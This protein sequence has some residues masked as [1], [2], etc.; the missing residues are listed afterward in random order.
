[1]VSVVDMGWCVPTKVVERVGWCRCGW[2][3]WGII[4]EV[5]GVVE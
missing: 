5:V 1:M 3:N 2:E 4:L